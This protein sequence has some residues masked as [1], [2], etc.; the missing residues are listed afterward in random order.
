MR[1]TAR[2]GPGGDFFWGGLGLKGVILQHNILLF[3]SLHLIKRSKSA[4]KN[5]TSSTFFSSFSISMREN[6]KFQKNVDL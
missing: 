2:H 6:M 4:R 3:L 1:G 5:I